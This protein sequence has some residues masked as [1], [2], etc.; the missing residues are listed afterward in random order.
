MSHMNITVTGNLIHD[1]EMLHFD[2]DKY[3]TKF[4]LASSRNY[5]TGEAGENGKPVWQETDLLFLDVE[6][7]GQLAINAKASL[8]KGAPVVVIGSLV[9]D[10]W[11][12]QSQLDAEGR[13]ATRQKIVLKAAKIS[14]ELS[15]YQVSSQRTS[16]QSNTPNG[17][18]PVA[19][20]TGAD[21]APETTLRR[22]SA[23]D[24]APQAPSEKSGSEPG[25][26]EAGAQ[27]GEAPF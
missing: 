17:M 5:R 6:V 22:T 9:T 1:P 13:P 14:F 2:S 24:M 12:D 16:N 4:R 26:A 11:A 10:S 15:N 21:L 19:L 7:W 20:K 3:L 27:A 8:F 23:E 18:E 25:F